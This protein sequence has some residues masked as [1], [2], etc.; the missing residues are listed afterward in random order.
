M[1]SVVYILEKVLQDERQLVEHSQEFWQ[2][3]DTV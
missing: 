1:H 3:S 2:H